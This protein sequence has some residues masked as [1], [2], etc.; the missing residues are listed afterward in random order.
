MRAHPHKGR[1]NGGIRHFYFLKI[2]LNIV[3]ICNTI[4]YGKHKKKAILAA[5]HRKMPA[6]ACLMD[7]RDFGKNGLTH[8]LLRGGMPSF[9]LEAELKE[10]FWRSFVSDGEKR[11]WLNF[12]L[13]YLGNFCPLL[14]LPAQPISCRF[15]DLDGF[16]Y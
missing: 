10:P 1:I 7:L 9:F 5:E 15:A 13:L 8:R 2:E 12:L 11:R 4:C 14:H 6:P 16:T 3:C